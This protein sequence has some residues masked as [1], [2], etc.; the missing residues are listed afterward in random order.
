[1]ITG[2]EVQK[3]ADSGHEQGADDRVEQRA[4]GEVDQGVVDEVEN[5]NH[6]GGVGQGLDQ[7]LATYKQL[8]R[9]GY[10]ANLRP[11][12]FHMF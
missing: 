4:D 1:M 3:W 8:K 6:G 12:I 10:K 11:D 2:G 7:V 9:C 5:G